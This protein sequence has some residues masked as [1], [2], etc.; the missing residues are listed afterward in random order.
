MPIAPDDQQRLDALKR[1]FVL[2]H[3][4]SESE[5]ERLVRVAA[6]LYG[7][8]YAALTLRQDNTERLAVA[9]GFDAASVP[10][11]AVFFE[12][13]VGPSLPIS[14]PDVS[15]DERFA[16][17]PLVH[18]E[19]QAHFY[20]SVPLKS[21]EGFTLGTLAILDATPQELNG[22][23]LAMLVDLGALVEPMLQ[24][25][26]LQADHQDAKVA[27]TL[28][29]AL[30]TAALEAAAMLAQ[31]PKALAEA[32]GHVGAAAG[33]TRAVLV[34]ST[35]GTTIVRASWNAEG[36]EPLARQGDVLDAQ[37][38]DAWAAEQAVKHLIGCTVPGASGLVLFDAPTA[39]D[40]ADQA[41]VRTALAPLAV[42]LRPVDAEAG[43]HSPWADV[44]EHAPAPTLL[45]SGLAGDLYS[46]NAAARTL[47]GLEAETVTEQ[48]FA[49]FVAPTHTERLARFL[50]A[51]LHEVPMPI[52]VEVVDATGAERHVHLQAAP[53][54]L[55]G[56]AVVQ[57]LLH[58]VSVY[59]RN[60][61]ALLADRD[62]ALLRDRA[63]SQFMASMSHEIRGALTSILGYAELIAD[64][65]ET[66]TRDLIDPI[67]GSSTRLLRTLAAVMDVARLE[68]GGGAPELTPMA[69]GSV[70]DAVAGAYQA[71]ADER[72]LAF[73]AEDADMEA[74]AWADADALTRV[75]D[76][77]LANAFQFTEQGG[78]RVRV[79]A[80]DDWVC[81]EVQD[82]GVGIDPE[83]LP[84]LLDDEHLEAGGHERSGSG[85]G[86]TLTKRLVELM[87]GQITV[88]SLQG[89]GSVFR[90]VL[91]SA[92]S[93][94]EKAPASPEHLAMA[95]GGD[96]E[97]PRLDEETTTEPVD[98]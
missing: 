21:R 9:F 95:I 73:F 46:A 79:S 23:G 29:N 77:L 18:G 89:Q 30:A 93:D 16:K 48:R 2:D 27:L 10:D 17:N 52:E 1:F 76:H 7:V 58:D 64:E 37:A 40:E 56:Q 57:L 97:N 91:R 13:P 70:V 55:G 47:L 86:L 80:E 94:E 88:T 28:H 82:T 75:L 33:A 20:A 54:H 39:W 8:T 51:A 34:T 96:G 87:G 24:L 6:Q 50:A 92:P 22:E 84:H 71:Q 78:I 65:G 83:V 60:E 49:A 4:I 3:E 67:L 74:Y 35:D 38:L 19:Q 63:K 25:Q 11:D 32:F 72:D 15:E 59:R 14:I 62:R 90:V 68:T 85:F 36:T 12:R 81:I 26:H 42:V 5:L 98:D 61:A 45:V 69:I 44:V 53:V 41:A 66:E 31:E 43:A